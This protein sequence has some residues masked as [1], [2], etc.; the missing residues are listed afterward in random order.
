MLL[1]PMGVGKTTTAQ[2]LEQQYGYRCYSLA[3]PVRRV[4]EVAFPWL[5]GESKSVR[6]IYLQKT[7]WF[8]RD[9]HPNPIL[10]HAEVTLRAVIRPL[11]IDDGRTEEEAEWAVRHGLSVVVLTCDDTERRRRLIERDGTLPDPL[12]FRDTTECEWEKV[13]APRVDTSRLSPDEVAKAVLS[14]I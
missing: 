7:G 11:V 12:T 4:V 5:D 10:H 14:L 13:N 3:E 8:L 2:L 1:G 6:R 9:F